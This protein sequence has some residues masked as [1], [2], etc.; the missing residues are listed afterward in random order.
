MRREPLYIT[1]YQAKILD[2]AMKRRYT[3]DKAK[4]GFRKHRAACDAHYRY[5]FVC[6]CM[7][8]IYHTLGWTWTV[9]HM[10]IVAAAMYILSHAESALLLRYI[11]L[12]RRMISAIFI[13]GRKILVKE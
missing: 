7:T 8:G 10:L 9:S 3:V 6:L 11:K 1:K 5:I 4:R 12:I 13:G 2:S